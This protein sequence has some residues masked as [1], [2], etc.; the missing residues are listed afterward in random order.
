M[1]VL[2]FIIVGLIPVTIYEKLAAFDHT[3]PLTVSR[4][5][6]FVHCPSRAQK[7]CSVF[8]VFTLPLWLLQAHV[9]ILTSA[10]FWCLESVT[11]YAV[12]RQTYVVT[13]IPL[14][15]PQRM[16]HFIGCF[17]SENAY[18]LDTEIFISPLLMLLFCHSH[19]VSTFLRLVP[20]RA[21]ICKG[22]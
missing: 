7:I 3:I 10:A 14:V 15:F 9:F 17:S 13:S 22:D 4:I 16:G 2:S 1:E 6:I 20:G 19:C 8:S 18:Q 11:Y 12:K 21:R 5:R